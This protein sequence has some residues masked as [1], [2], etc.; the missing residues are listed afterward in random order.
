MNR[1]MAIGLA[2]AL[3]FVTP[4]TVRAQHGQGSGNTHATTTHGSSAATHGGQS[5][6]GS[7]STHTTKP[8][9]GPSTHGSSGKTTTTT[10][11]T[12]K[13]NAKSTTTTS[14][15]TTTTGST[16]T[17]NAV[18]QKLQKNTNL[19]SKLQTRLGG[20]DPMT[21]ANGQWRNFG[22]FVSAVNVSYNLKI[23][24]TELKTKLLDEG[25][26]L[27]QAIQ[28]LRPSTDGT[29]EAKRAETEA[30]D[31][32]RKTTTTTSSPT[33]TTT[34]KKSAKRPHAEG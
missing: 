34:H 31:M 33:S 12:T 8:S 27:G 20:L 22:Q 29:T 15:P 19:T 28:A 26:S 6:H 10:S 30:D 16:T 25:M 1:W 14:T 17:L 11:D 32:I 23:D 9:H 7:G 5:T 18:Q 3:V 13:K 21:A 4:A 2:T 24:F